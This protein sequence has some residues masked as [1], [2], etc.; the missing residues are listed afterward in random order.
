M[1]HKKLLVVMFGV[2]AAIED[3]YVD[4]PYFSVQTVTTVGY[5]NWWPPDVKE[6]D[7]RLFWVKIIS[8]PRMVAGA[9]LFVAAVAIGVNWLKATE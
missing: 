9:A 6:S 4:A 1:N 3:S 8:I 5:G 7:P 2:R